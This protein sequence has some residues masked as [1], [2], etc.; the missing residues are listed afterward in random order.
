MLPRVLRF[1]ALIPSLFL[2]ACAT[3]AALPPGSGAGLVSWDREAPTAAESFPAPHWMVGDRF[4][5]EKG[6]I[7]R[8]AYRVQSADP[9][10]GY[11]LREEK[12][13]LLL[14]L[15]PELAEVGQEMPG[16]PETRRRID[17]YDAIFSFPLWVGKRWS[18]EFLSKRPDQPP[19]P[20]LVNYSCDALETITVPAGSFRCL[21]IWR[22]ARVAAE[23]NYK[24]RVSLIWY[25]PEVGW[26]VRRLDDSL[27]LE[28]QEAHRQRPDL[29]GT[30]GTTLS[31]W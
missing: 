19:L 1:R 5:Y 27:L 18:C 30:P 23:G 3:P 29:P 13:G 17:P 9:K 11:T 22:R 2:A 10:Q 8:L 7:A 20:L 28:L 12:S 14:H 16:E 31:P 6:G 15:T 4:V 25:A 21:R 26:I 24:E